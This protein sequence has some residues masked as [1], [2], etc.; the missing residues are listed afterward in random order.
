MKLRIPL[1][2]LLLSLLSG[3]TILGTS[4]FSES[5]A[6]GCASCEADAHRAEYLEQ[7]RRSGFLATR[8][9]ALTTAGEVRSTELK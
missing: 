6:P 3:C 8:D 4:M 7:I 5:T 1:C 2:V 9:D